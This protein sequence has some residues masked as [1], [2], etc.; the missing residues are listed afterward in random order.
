MFLTHINYALL[1][2]MSCKDVVRTTVRDTHA[3]TKSCFRGIINALK[4]NRY[5]KRLLHLLHFVKLLIILLSALLNTF[6][7]SVTVDES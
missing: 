3:S 4:H 5:N 6:S 1:Y 2:I 7:L